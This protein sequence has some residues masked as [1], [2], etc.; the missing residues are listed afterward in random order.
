MKKVFRMKD[1]DC[2]HCAAKMERNISK[3]NGVKECSVNF[4]MQ[5]LVLEIADDADANALF[6]AI[7]A[8]VKKVEPDC[9]IVGL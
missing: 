6:S 9:E 1:L 3:L 2:A 5:K 7:K 4:M 8:E